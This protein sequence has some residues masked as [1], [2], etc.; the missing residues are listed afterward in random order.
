MTSSYLLFALAEQ[1]FAV[2]LVGAIEIL[3]W[4]ES[5][6]VPLAYSYVEGLLDYRGTIYPV[7]NLAERLG[8]GKPGPIGFTAEDKKRV[9][10]GKSIILLEEKKQPFGIVVDRVVKMTRLEEQAAAPEKGQ[11][12]DPRYIKGFVTDED[13]KVWVLDFERLF[14]AD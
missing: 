4:R 6:R 3:P 11:K 13:H 12:V 14:H 8:I 9:G 5:R 10:E 7:Y 1:L 2:Q